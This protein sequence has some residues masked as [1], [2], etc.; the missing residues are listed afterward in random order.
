MSGTL[1]PFKGQDSH[2][3][4]TL[5]LT[6]DGQQQREFFLIPSMCS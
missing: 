5:T 1:Q 2:G 6:I 4:N 3:L